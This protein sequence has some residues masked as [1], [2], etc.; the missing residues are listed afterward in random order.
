[1][2]QSGYEYPLIFRNMKPHTNDDDLSR[3]PL[4]VE[5]V[6]MEAPS[7]LVL[8]AEHMT[9]SLVMADNIHTWTRKVL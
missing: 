5:S 9:N 2:F 7:E 1:M 4:P 3:L 6:E 8:L